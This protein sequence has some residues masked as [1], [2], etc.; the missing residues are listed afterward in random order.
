MV[1]QKK[2]IKCFILIFIFSNMKQIM[3]HMFSYQVFHICAITA[4][5]FICFF[6]N[7][8]SLGNQWNIVWKNKNV[9][10]FVIKNIYSYIFIN[11][12]SF[13][14]LI[15][16]S[17]VVL[18]PRVTHLFHKNIFIV[19]FIV[20]SYVFIKRF[21]GGGC[22]TPGW[23]SDLYSVTTTDDRLPPDSVAASR[24]R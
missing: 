7:N 5:L 15:F 6:I 17:V 4:M 24:A 2:D 9:W 13:S 12:I 20:I 1:E 3:F 14:Y 23:D 18:G 11:A 21:I 19:V 22:Q 8:Y 10:K 16:I